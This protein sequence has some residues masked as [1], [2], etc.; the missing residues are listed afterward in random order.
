[1]NIYTYEKGEARRFEFVIKNTENETIVVTSAFW[2]LT[3]RN[4]VVVSS[5]ECSVD[6]CEISFVLPMTVRGELQLELTVVI[7]PETIKE[8]MMIRVVD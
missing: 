4:K 3:D 1:M 8:R 7:P 5:G 6:G 2:T